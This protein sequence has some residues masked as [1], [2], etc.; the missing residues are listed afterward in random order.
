MLNWRTLFVL[1][2][3]AG[4]LYSLPSIYPPLEASDPQ[5]AIVPLTEGLSWKEIDDPTE[6]GW[7]T[8]AMADSAKKQLELLGNLLAHPSGIDADD[9]ENLITGDFACG[10]LQPDSTVTA[11]DDPHFKIERASLG[12]LP[13]TPSMYLPKDTDL[14]YRGADGLTRAMQTAAGRFTEATNVRF[15]VKVFHVVPGKNEISTRQY[16]SISGR[17]KSGIVEQ[18]STWDIGWTVGARGAAPRMR[19]LHVLEFEQTETRQPTGPLFTDCTASVLSGNHCYAE[20][21]LRGMNHWYGRIQDHSADVLRS[22]PGLA[23]GDVNGDG[24]DDLYVCQEFGLPNRLFIQASD[25]T[26]RDESA[27]WG[28]N[29]LESSR[30]ALL[31]DLDNDSDQ[32]LVVAIQ[33]GVV[34]AEN[35]GRG[36]FSLRD[37]LDTTADTMSLSA[38][39]VDRDGRLDIY[40][41]GY[42]QDEREVISDSRGLSANVS[43]DASNGGSN[44]LF[45]NEISAARSWHFTDVTNEVGLNENNHR[46]SLAASWDDFDND[47]DQ[48]LY[49][50]NDYGRDHFYRNDLI[51]PSDDRAEQA[52]RGQFVDI[53]DSAHVE[54]SAAGMSITWGDY[55]RD[56]WMDVLVSNM[57]SSAGKR[58]TYQRKFQ[59]GAPPEMKQRYQR[60]ARGNTLLRNQA[61]GTFGDRSAQAGI[62]M[63]RWAW[64]SHFVDLNSDGWEDLIVANGF[65]TTDDSGD[66]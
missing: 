3:V 54:D 4:A 19:R 17:T 53:S 38:V 45:R 48:D 16:F 41:C 12:P 35:D 24:L 37:V 6:D 31:V 40:V 39:D 44:S 20:Q 29:W 13:R 7:E 49:V 23:V 28:V 61:D 56:G 57:W 18:H 55:D 11:L 10:P 59:E 27:A 58:I 51:S 21:F 50:A 43:H 33:G 34:V 42:V 46:Y 36:R 5:D 63:G 8:E 47:G 25:G 15:E 22:S 14:R 26:A 62:E 66:L 32:D 65:L 60:F 1:L 9:V 64:G 2:T 52:T 30:S